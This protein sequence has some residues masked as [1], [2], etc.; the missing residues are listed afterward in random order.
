MGHLAYGRRSY[1]GKADTP[2][3]TNLKEEGGGSKQ[4][5]TPNAAA[6]SQTLPNSLFAKRLFAPADTTPAT[7]VERQPKNRTFAKTTPAPARTEHK[8][9]TSA[10]PFTKNLPQ[11]STARNQQSNSVTSVQPVRP[12][13][14]PLEEFRR[15]LYALNATPESVW[16]AWW[17]IRES[18][19]T[20]A[21]LEPTDKSDLLKYIYR[22][23]HD[24]RAGK[25]WHILNSLAKNGQELREAHF[26]MLFDAYGTNINYLLAKRALAF[27]TK[28]N[29]PLRT[30]LFNRI[31]KNMSET[32][33]LIAD[34]KRL[35]RV[36]DATSTPKDAITYATILTTI[37][38][39]PDPRGE[40]EP[41][42]SDTRK[43]SSNIAFATT[44]ITDYLTSPICNSEDIQLL[45]VP[46]ANLITAHARRQ[47]LSTAEKLF[48][49]CTS[50]VLP[51]SVAIYNAMI[52]AYLSAGDES[53]ANALLE[54]ATCMNLPYP[55][56]GCCYAYVVHYSK[57]GD[58]P[59]MERE[60]DIYQN[61]VMRMPLKAGDRKTIANKAIYKAM[62]HGYSA[63]GRG[64][65]C[66][67]MVEK[68]KE[69]KIPIDTFIFGLV[70]EGFV[71]GGDVE[72]A[73]EVFRR[74]EG[75]GGLK[76]DRK[77]FKAVVQGFVD[78]EMWGEV[79][80][81]IGEC[82]GRGIR[83][84]EW[85]KEIK[86]KVKQEKVRGAGTGVDAEI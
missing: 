73:V 18:N 49:L 48:Q 51:P 67:E 42:T 69:V 31:L 61:V 37:L 3:D 17:K 80:K 21:A 12:P 72:S 68:M 1:S 75:E 86:V 64:R 79:G 41:L 58:I 23:P 44:H 63:A 77:C 83:A 60:F 14:T 52:Q 82:E 35:V 8:P 7:D 54:E 2:S 53:R 27:M 56:V 15:A 10:Q 45:N 26:V 71:K 36:M 22:G 28:Q 46:L 74:M 78:R 30:D 39:H 62:V 57:K 50:S 33:S 47:S 40:S 19:R 65:E 29:I 16:A 13:E 4:P 34:F 6:D 24:K 43:S 85:M 59:S 5:P 32:A 66:M 70:L 76:A 55:N 11:P 84:D 9:T 20:Q 25:L 81:W 38:S